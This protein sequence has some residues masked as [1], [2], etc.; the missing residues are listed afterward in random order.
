VLQIIKTNQFNPV[1]SLVEA[2]CKIHTPMQNQRNK[3]I[4]FQYL[5]TK[6]SIQ[7]ETNSP[8]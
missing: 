2:Q 1:I 7:K 6:V 5:F 4:N 8:M 3:R